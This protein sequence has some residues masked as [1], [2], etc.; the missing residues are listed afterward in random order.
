MFGLGVLKGLGI[1]LR[2]FIDTF[3]DDLKYFPGGSKTNPDAFARR[4]GPTGAGLF[5]VEYPE[6]KLKTPEN[7]RFIPFLVTDYDVVKDDPAYDWDKANELN[8]CTSCGICSKVCPPQC[9]WIVRTNDPKTGKPIPQ[10]AEFYIDTDICMNCGYC[11]E[12]C[13]F[14]AI[15]MDHDYELSDYERDVAHVHNLQ[16]LLKPV[17]YYAR[18][19]PSWHAQEEE[20]KRQAEEE[21]RRKEE[22]KARVAAEKAAAAKAAA[23]AKAKADSAPPAGKRS[24]EEIKAQR[25]AM[26]ARRAAKAAGEELPPEAPAEKPKRSPEEIKAQRDAMMARR[27][28]K[29]VGEEPPPE[30]PAEKPKRTP[31]EIKAQRDA[32]MARRAAK[33]AG[34]PVEEEAK[35]AEPAP[36]AE[37]PKRTPEEIK[38]QRDAMMARRAAKA[39]GLPVEEESKPAEPAPVKADDL[40]K[41]EGIG[42]K[43]SGLLQ[44]AGIKTFAQLAAA[45]V[46][47]L[48][49]ILD[50]ASLRLA[51]PGTWPEQAQLAANGEWDALAK[52][53]DELHHGKRT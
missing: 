38:A 51:D 7:F 33:A 20:I 2:H 14:D 44:E 49:E 50:A 36:P 34:L 21:K 19:R 1:T 53:Q 39:A 35:P 3:V 52:L 6:M 13:P 9:I 48:Q 42:P 30:A 17:S 28:A 29:A 8:R 22:E 11:A 18:I 16:R 10:P 32:M 26:M 5:T 46:S 40:T 4:Q 23:E 24:P 45:E 31:E 37:K 47:R 43:I 41:I 12:F 27:A 25:E 15:K